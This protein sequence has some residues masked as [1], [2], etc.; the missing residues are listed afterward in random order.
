MADA[1]INK[2][3]LA[4]SLL[5]IVEA[6]TRMERVLEAVAKFA[7]RD[8]RRK[9]WPPGITEDLAAVRRFAKELEVGRGF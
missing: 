8:E 3:E 7:H 5:T 6:M 2:P 9:I 4:K 1:C